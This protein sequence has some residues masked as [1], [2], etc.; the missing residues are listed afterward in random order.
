MNE[1]YSFSYTIPYVFVAIILIV[2]SII[3]NNRPVYRKTL[4]IISIVI[5]I[6]FFGFRGFVCWDWINYYKMFEYVD[7]LFHFSASSFLIID[8]DA[9]HSFDMVEPG[10]ILYMSTIKTLFNNWYFFILVSTI[11]DLIILDRF[12]RQ[13]SFNYVFSFLIYFCLNMSMEFD[14]MRNIKALLVFLISIPYLYKKNYIAL[15]LF[16]LLGMSFH[17]SYLLFVPMYFVG[18]RCVNKRVLLVVFIILNIIY[19][20]QIPILSILIQPIGAILGGSFEAKI[21][22][23]STNDLY[24]NNGGID[25]GYIIRVI[26]FFFIIFLYKPILNLSEKYRFILNIY[27]IYLL[28]YLGMSDLPYLV[29]RAENI[30]GF[31]FIILYPLILCFLKRKARVYF[32]I[33]VCSYC[34][35]ATIG[36]T[37]SSMLEYENIL[38]G[39][40]SYEERLSEKQYVISAIVSSKLK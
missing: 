3:Y 10:F 16:T 21:Q 26:A 24:A 17:R 18:M 40:K 32:F 8:S 2:C 38:F 12:V 7:T 4:R 36:K 13:Y 37:R 14:L 31:I 20:C 34:L 15:I 1:L 5:F 27:F 39:A 29:D 11:I 23:Y 35:Y 22:G 9:S 30:Y 33:Y 28:I 19:F 25:M 6:L